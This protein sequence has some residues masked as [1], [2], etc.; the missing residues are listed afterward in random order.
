MPPVRPPGRLPLAVRAP[1]ARRLSSRP[2]ERSPSARTSHHARSANTLST[3]T[4]SARVRRRTRRIIPNVGSN[5]TA[6]APSWLASRPTSADRNHA[7]PRPT[8]QLLPTTAHAPGI[9]ALRRPAKSLRLP[10]RRTPSRAAAP[11]AQ[12]PCILCKSAY[13]FLR[14]LSFA[15]LLTLNVQTLVSYSY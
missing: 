2:V 10:R 12:N 9:A 1:Y 8:R 15:T 4:P 7:S 11:L 13:N 5:L 3:T 14:L 6:L